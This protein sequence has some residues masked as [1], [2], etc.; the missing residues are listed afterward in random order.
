MSS[1]AL[2][3]RQRGI[4]EF[5]HPSENFRQAQLLSVMMVAKTRGGRGQASLI[6]GQSQTASQ[7]V[8]GS[9]PIWNSSAQDSYDRILFKS[10]SDQKGGRW[11]MRLQGNFKIHQL[12]VE[13]D[14]NPVR[15][16]SLDYS[17]FHTKT[18][19]G[20]QDTLRLKR[21]AMNQLG[22]SA[23]A[24]ELVAVTVVAKSRRGGGQ[25][26]LVVGQSETAT[27]TISSRTA[28]KAIFIKTTSSR[29]SC[30]FPL[31]L[32]SLLQ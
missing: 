22:F 18:G 25:A 26:S 31:S 11:Q 15:N 10:P 23:N 16:V 13:V 9:R 30:L 6:V 1:A 12:M 14:A 17:G 21:E 7:V 28:I 29:G 20:G 32:E 24:H 3:V 2:I 27:Q 4:T 8:A 19:Q 5:L